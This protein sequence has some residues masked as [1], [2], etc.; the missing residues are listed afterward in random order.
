MTEVRQRFSLFKII[1]ES[2]GVA[3]RTF[4]VGHAD[5]TPGALDP[6]LIPPFFLVCLCF[7]GPTGGSAPSPTP[8]SSLSMMKSVSWSSDAAQEVSPESMFLLSSLFPF[9]LVF[10]LHGSFY[11]ALHFGL[12]PPYFPPVLFS[13]TEEIA[14]KSGVCLFVFSPCASRL[15][16]TGDLLLKDPSACQSSQ[17]ASS[18]PLQSLH[19]YCLAARNKNFNLCEKKKKKKLERVFILGNAWYYY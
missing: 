10:P 11:Y 16:G 13:L 12:F 19:E 4:V 1:W 3:C 15:G 18:P 6:F 5:S 7:P 14:T 8:C 9:S 2:F 17:L